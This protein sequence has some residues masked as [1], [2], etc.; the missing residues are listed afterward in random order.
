MNEQPISVFCPKSRNLS[1]KFCYQKLTLKNS[2][3]AWP[4]IP[5]KLSAMQQIARKLHRKI[6]RTISTKYLLSLPDGYTEQPKK[7]W[8]VL[9]FLHG[10]GERGDN[11]ALVKV[12]GPPKLIAQ[13]QTFPFIV[14]SPQCPA[15][16]WWRP[17]AL[18]ALL[19]EI[20]RLYRVDKRRIYLTGMS[21]G[22]FGTW[23]SALEFPHRFA[24]IV[25]ICGGGHWWVASRI[26]HLPVW[27]FHGK[28][29]SIVS[30]E[31]SAEMVAALRQCGG[32]VKFTTYPNA[33]HDSWSA[34]YTNPK[35][36]KWLLSHAKPAA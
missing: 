26:K 2:R 28:K 32:D 30:H 25:P 15:N 4:V 8:P 12:H 29:D 31:R 14:V 20:E 13:G 7:K 34:T 9:L 11:L 24:A 23:A 6:T 3:F 1:N 36:Y 16:D 10:A 19:D 35:L 33:A 17:D 27:V 18:A 21:M 5:A 22:G